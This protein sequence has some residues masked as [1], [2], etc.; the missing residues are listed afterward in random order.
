MRKKVLFLLMAILSLYLANAQG[1]LPEGITFSTQE[2]IDR[3]QANFPGC[4]EIEG[5]VIISGVDITNLNGLNTLVSIGGSLE[6]GTSWLPTNNQHLISLSGL[7]L[8]TSIGGDLRI[9]END[10]LSDIFAFSNLTSV[11]GNIEI[12]EN[13]ALTNLSGLENLTSI[14]GTIGIFYNDNMVNLGGLQNLIF[15]GGA[16]LIFDNYLLSDLD[17]LE[18][19]TSIGGDFSIS[20]NAITNLNGLQNLSTIGGHLFISSLMLTSLNGLESLTSIGDFLGIGDNQALTDINGLANVTYIGGYLS[21]ANNQ[22]L[23][24]CDVYSICDYLAAPNGTIEIHD[25]ASGCNSQAEVETACITS[26]ENTISDT[27][28]SIY[29]NPC[30]DFLIISTQNGVSPDDVS[31]YNLAGQKV[32]HSKSNNN[33]LDISRLRSGIYIVELVTGNGKMRKKLMVE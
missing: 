31:V 16:M 14:P 22:Y 7:E 5:I 23:S 28:I 32:Q 19:L 27:Q 33:I 18:S 11:G 1:C 21:I 3:F 24:D 26:L 6:I 29:P 30:K 4:T 13:D 9:S 2:Q 17:D 12:V 8:L 20:G 15:V 10:S 25:N